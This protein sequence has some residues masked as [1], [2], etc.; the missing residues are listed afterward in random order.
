MDEE[1]AIA[2]LLS[3][4]AA[5]SRD[6]GAPPYPLAQGCQDHLIGLAIDEAVTCDAIVTTGTEAWSGSRIVGSR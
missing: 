2:S 5:W 4:T 1:I 3:A 6:V